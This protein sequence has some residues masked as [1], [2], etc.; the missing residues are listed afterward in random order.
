[1]SSE[2]REEK[3]TI[4]SNGWRIGG[5]TESSGWIVCK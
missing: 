2:G 4:G 5:K 3:D 1:M